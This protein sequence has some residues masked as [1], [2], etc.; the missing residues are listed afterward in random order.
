MTLPS[1]IAYSAEPPEWNFAQEADWLRKAWGIVLA[2]LSWCRVG[3]VRSRDVK[4]KL[5]TLAGRSI[6]RA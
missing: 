1:P 3:R 2:T 5:G 4:D 6:A